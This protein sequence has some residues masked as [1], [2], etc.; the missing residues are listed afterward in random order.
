MNSPSDS[1]SLYERIGG[2]E[3]VDA[4]VHDFY[5]RVLKDPELAPFFEH[6]SIDKLRSMQQEFFAAALG[7]PQEYSGRSL[8]AVHHGRNIQRSHFS[9]FCQHLFETLEEMGFDRNDI[10]E[11]VRRIAMSARDV[12]G[13]ANVDG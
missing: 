11:T 4:L 12:T 8:A 10:D 6:S 1:S 5:E 7:G 9:K 3:R 13:E 2:A